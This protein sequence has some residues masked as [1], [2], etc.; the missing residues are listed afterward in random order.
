MRGHWGI[1][2]V[3]G[4]ISVSAS[5]ADFALPKGAGKVEFDAIGSPSSLKIHGT[6]SE[7]EG[8]IHSTPQ[9]LT[10]TF[11]VNLESLSTG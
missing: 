4:V 7:I 10:G 11:E 2:A 5:A 3:V 6:T 9:A 1:L 8:K